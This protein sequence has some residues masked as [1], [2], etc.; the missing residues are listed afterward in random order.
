MIDHDDFAFF[1]LVVVKLRDEFISFDVGAWVVQG[2]SN[3]ILLVVFRLS[4]IDKEKIGLKAHWQLFCFDG[5]RG[6]VGDLTPGIF[7]RLI[8]GINGLTFFFLID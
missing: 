2:L 8:P 1:V 3:M 7:L 6:E 4:E 5:D